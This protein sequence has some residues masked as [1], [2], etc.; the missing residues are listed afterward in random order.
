[1][2]KNVFLA[3][4]AKKKIGTLFLARFWILDGAYGINEKKNSLLQFVLLEILF[5]LDHK[6]AM[7][8]VDLIG[9]EPVAMPTIIDN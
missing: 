9:L 5:I 6:A 8:I 2:R 7:L 1:M 4:R 3:I